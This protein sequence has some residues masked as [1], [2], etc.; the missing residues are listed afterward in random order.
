MYRAGELGEA[1]NDLILAH[2]SEM[3]VP[4]HDIEIGPTCTSTHED[5]A[6]IGFT[7]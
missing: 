7:L 4:H 1:G 2:R 6:A 3:V 5:I